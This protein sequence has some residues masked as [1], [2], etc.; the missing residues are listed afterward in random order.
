MRKKV[1]FGKVS[2]QFGNH[3]QWKTEGLGTNLGSQFVLF[4]IHI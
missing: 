1:G 4:D 3:L 2:R